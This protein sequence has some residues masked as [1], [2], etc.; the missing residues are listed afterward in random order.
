M[1][2]TTR[3]NGDEILSSWFN[4]IK[5]EIEGGVPST[6]FSSFAD[7]AA[8]VTDK[9]SAAA[10]G[11]AYYDT[12]LDVIKIYADGAWSQVIDNDT[13]Q[14]MSSKTLTSPAING[15]NQNMGT[16]S[17]TNR[18]VLP[19]NTTSNLAG[20]TDTAG[21]IAYDSDQLKPVY[22]DG[23]GWTAIGTGSGGGKNYISNPDATVNADDTTSDSN[24]TIARNTT[25]PLRPDGDFVLTKASG[26][27]YS[28][29]KVIFAMD[30]LDRADL[31]SVMKVTFDYDFTDADYT[32]DE[33]G[34]IAYDNDQTNEIELVPRGIKAG[35][36]TY[37]GYFQTHATSTD[38]DLWIINDKTTDSEIVGYVD[39]VSV[40]PAQYSFGPV[41]SDNIDYTATLGNMGN[42]TQDISYNRIG[43]W[44][45]IVGKITIGSTLPTGDFEIDI[46]AG[47]T[48]DTGIS[49]AVGTV[50]GRDS[51]SLQYAGLPRGIDSNTIRISGPQGENYWDDAIPFTWS[52]SDTL[53]LNIWVPILGWSSSQQISEDADTRVVACRV[54]GDAA[55]ASV[56]NPIIFPTVD[57]DT[58]GVYGT[59]T[60]L[61]TTPCSGKYRVSGYI[62]SANA[63]ITLNIAVDGA[64]DMPGGITDGNGEG[65]FI[66]LVNVAAGQTIS[67]EPSGTLDITSG[68]M[69][70]ERLSGPSSIAASEL[71][72]ARYTT[73]AGQT[74]A[75]AATDIIDFEDLTDGFDSHGAVTIGAAW[76][77]T[78]PASGIYNI[79]SFVLGSAAAGEWDEGE[80]VIL[81]IYKNGATYTQLDRVEAAT[82]PASAILIALIG[83]TT[84]DL[85][86]G[87]YVDIRLYNGVGANWTVQNSNDQAYVSIT[88]QGF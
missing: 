43:Q 80:A 62:V 61:Y 38:Y 17:D 34:V 36:G 21:L 77:F 49:L 6:S 72:K 32:D 68:Y 51:T 63:T 67:L 11:D 33:F 71:V 58:H 14:T 76:K 7:D 13:A 81:Y 52:E 1:V 26:G 45:H 8:F 39:N 57:F 60:G 55:S 82:S 30:T 40:G 78:A 54:S 37:V 66:G 41:V 2:L 12:T 10:D 70:I 47:L 16:A 15:A 50:T 24:F 3:S 69:C 75:N 83:N 4:D 29:Q 46:P 59:G 35:K 20:L 84:I 88:R 42:A 44:M 74:I 31:A 9:G 64:T 22:N 27:D 5:T 85:N 19:D 25:T 18:I 23:T 79:S 48:M 87:D 56:G 53:Y 73:N 28:T 86:K 65:N